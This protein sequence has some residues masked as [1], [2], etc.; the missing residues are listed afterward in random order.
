MKGSYLGPEFDDLS[1]EDKLKN[2]KANFVKLSEE[3]C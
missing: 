1:V 2:L 3:K